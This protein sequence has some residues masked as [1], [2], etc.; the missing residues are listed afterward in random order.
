M[1][2]AGEKSVHPPYRP[3]IDGLRA[4]AILAVVRFYLFPSRIHGGF[5]GV[6]IFFVISPCCALLPTIGT[7]SIIAAGPQSWLNRDPARESADGLDRDSEL[8]DLSLPLAAD[9][10][11]ANGLRPTHSDEIHLVA[12]ETA[13]RAVFIDDIVK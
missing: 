8:S 1:M 7:F 11:P 10:V 13:K 2:H 4:V 6:D 5:V 9:F 12:S 3:D